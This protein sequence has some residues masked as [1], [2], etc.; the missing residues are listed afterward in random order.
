MLIH[1]SQYFIM[2]EYNLRATAAAHMAQ[3]GRSISTGT[4][5]GVGSEGQSG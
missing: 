3:R 1:V 5:T 2:R 4:A